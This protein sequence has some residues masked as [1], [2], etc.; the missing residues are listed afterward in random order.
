MIGIVT[1]SYPR[2]RGDAAGN[3]VAGHARALLALGHRVEVIAAGPPAGSG[4]PSPPDHPFAVDALVTR[5]PSRLFYRGGAPDL[6]ER[7][8]VAGAVAAASFTFRLAAAVRRRRWDHLIA[9]WLA[10]SAIACL[11]AR[12]PLLA[13]AHGGDIHTLRRLH[14]LA[15]VLHALRARRAK[16]VFVADELRALSRRAA[17]SLARWLDD[18][19]VQP[20]GVDV[21]RFAALT[22]GPADPPHVLV[23]A[24]LVPVKGVDVAIDAMTRLPDVRLV[25]AGDGPERT[26]LAER[27]PANVTFL[28]EVDAAARDRLLA[29]ASVVVVPSRVLANGRSEGTP[30]IALEALA[31][32]VP[33]VA[34][35][36]GGLGDLPARLV[37]PE[38]PDALA[39]AIRNALSRREPAPPAPADWQTVARRLLAHSQ[40]SKDHDG[41]A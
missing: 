16:L 14:L 37:P 3:F 26:S 24:R 19:I 39:T 30:T 13:I 31:A 41:R 27:A 28:G 8:P 23:A 34:S 15:P 4:S 22:R 7:A 17:P 20:M 35:A 12:A 38:D 29:A 21:A 2:W 11:P 36:V 33:V 32:G 40:V 9:H 1:T 25:V 18:A 5:I 6:L 10:P